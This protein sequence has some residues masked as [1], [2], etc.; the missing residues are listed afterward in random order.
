MDTAAAGFLLND[1]LID[2]GLDCIS[3][4]GTTVKIE[5]RHMRVLL[6]L[7]K[8]EGEVVS[9]R[10]IEDYIWG[11]EIV[12][13]N[14][15]HQAIAQLRRA[16]GDDRKAPRYIQTVARRGYRL[17]AQPTAKPPTPPAIAAA[18]GAPPANPEVAAPTV[19]GPQAF[20][21]RPSVRPPTSP[22]RTPWTVGTVTLLGVLVISM[23]FAWGRWEAAQAASARARA[24]QISNFVLNVFTAERSIAAGKEMTAEELTAHAL[25]RI[26]FELREQP[27][28]QA[29]M[30]EAIAASYLKTG[31]SALAVQPLREAVKIRR[32]IGSKTELGAVLQSLGGSLRDLG[33][34]AAAERALDEAA[35]LIRA[36]LGERSLAYA[37][38]T[39]ERGSLDLQRGR[40]E[41]AL[42]RLTY[43]LQRVRIS[44]GE[45][46][47]D[48]ALYLSNVGAAHRLNGNLTSAE[49]ALHESLRIYRSAG[50]EL[51]PG[52]A[53]A[54]HALGELLLEQNR[55]DEASGVLERALEAQRRVELGANLQMAMMLATLGQVRFKQGRIVQG[56]VL[57]SEAITVQRSSGAN[58]DELH[59]KYQ[60][61]LAIEL[62]R[63]GQ[64]SRSER[65]LRESMQLC[66]T[67]N[68]Q[69][70]IATAEHFIAETLLAQNRVA[71]SEAFVNSAMERLR[72]SNAPRWQFERCS[73]LLGE[74]LVK[75][76]RAEQGELR[77]MSSYQW[78][79][80][81]PKTPMAEKD[82]AKIRMREL[83]LKP[84]SRDLSRFDGRLLLP[85]RR[86]LSDVSSKCS[87]LLEA[88]RQRHP[89]LPPQRIA[90]ERV[91]VEVQAGERWVAVGEV[92]HRSCQGHIP[93][94]FQPVR[95]IVRE[96]RA[97][98]LARRAGRHAGAH[99]GNP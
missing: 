36:Q 52:R 44:K 98:L 91:V 8:H 11:E 65:L 63:L 82:R 89:H 28:V 81:D 49:R 56:E 75:S 10:Q 7:A 19:N 3:R 94:H 57:I 92:E 67:A 96:E 61:A 29:R 76:G 69:A 50:S 23:T 83:R 5:Q 84:G 41:I 78:L 31:N 73:N 4:D 17:I 37:I 53:M 95:H 26:G 35:T 45:N 62:L 58:G 27:R 34:Y 70:C 93:G 25:Q 15:V 64:F 54:E 1:W 9:I 99:I 97:D 85:T 32:R 74:I 60:R 42:T 77:V 59:A 21:H 79:S 16:L 48:T 12:T 68:H 90:E 72:N 86:S 43:C 24:D 14:V 80:N 38:V 55:L 22:W 39:G 20:T 66:G 33:N 2:P 13:Q 40:Y 46:H 51:A 88:L 87:L 18:V 30:L 47:T 6:L 71:E